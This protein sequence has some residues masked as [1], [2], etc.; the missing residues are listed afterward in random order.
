MGF[1]L[2]EKKLRLD[3]CYDTSIVIGL[4][5]TIS[6]HRKP[7]FYP[8]ATRI[9]PWDRLHRFDLVDIPQHIIQRGNNRHVSF[10]SEHKLAI[11]ANW[12]TEYAQMFA[13]FSEDVPALVRVFPG[14]GERE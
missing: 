10:A 4:I 8:D 6:R 1:Q 2:D 13:V 9:Q 5:E 14:L 7:Y 3:E 11:C 12:L